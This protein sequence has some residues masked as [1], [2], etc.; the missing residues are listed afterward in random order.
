M[1]GNYEN[2]GLLFCCK[3]CVCNYNGTYPIYN[4]TVVVSDKD[5]ELITYLLTFLW[6]DDITTYHFVSW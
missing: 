6:V 2:L 5:K 1:A 3:M 4:G